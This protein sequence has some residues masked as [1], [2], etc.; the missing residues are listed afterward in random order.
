VRS[1]WVGCGCGG[2]E[3]GGCGWFVLLGWSVMVLFVV[4]VV[5]VGVGVVYMIGAGWLVGWLVAW[6]RFVL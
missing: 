4:L 2:G 3:E 6:S 1:G 5:G